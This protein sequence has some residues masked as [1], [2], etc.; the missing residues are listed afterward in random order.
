MFERGWIDPT[1]IREYTEK[2]KKE[3]T[4]T[5]VNPSSND[6]ITGCNFSIRE[7]M[8]HQ[9]DFV[10]EITLMQ[11]YGNKMGVVVDR[12]PKCHPELAGE[13]IEY[14]W[15]IAK[16]FYRKSPIALKRSKSLFQLLVRDST[17]NDK[18]LTIHKIRACS[19]KARTYMKMYMA[20]ESLDMNNEN[21]KDN[22]HSVMEGAMKL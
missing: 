8:K 3:S 6:D 21:F 7:L 17:D 14:A 10:E 5:T 12:T 11:Y 22:K 4:S 1:R 9:K 18:V 15:A 2:G 20:L 19:R 16:L 13:G